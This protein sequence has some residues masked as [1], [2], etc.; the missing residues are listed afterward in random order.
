MKIL[1]SLFTLI[2]FTESCNSTKETVS[3]TQQ[4]T[5]ASK[6]NKEMTEEKSDIVKNNYK[7]IITYQIASR[8]FY[9]YFSV[10]ESDITFSKDSGLQNMDNYNCKKK[11]WTE[12][13]EL[14]EAVNLDAFQKLKAPTSKRATDAALIANLAIQIGD[15][16]YMAPEFD[17][18]NPPK[19]VEA[20]VNKVLSIK[21]NTI[22]Q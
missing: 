11:N 3:D 21:E 2:V 8:G 9:E 6:T 20:L 19:E 4:I 14:I 7:T 17:H 22:K 13:N 15:V 16:Y 5:T 18:G 12:L 10:S 1:L